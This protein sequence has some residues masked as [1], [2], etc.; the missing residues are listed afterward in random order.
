MQSPIEYVP[1]VDR[2]GS[3][4]ENRGYCDEPAQGESAS[5]EENRARARRTHGDRD[6]RDSWY[7]RRKRTASTNPGGAEAA[8]KRYLAGQIV[9]ASGTQWR[10][11]ARLQDFDGRWGRA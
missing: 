6:S 4:D 10:T 8:D 5:L 11:A 7:Q 2:I 9:V 1:R 3:A